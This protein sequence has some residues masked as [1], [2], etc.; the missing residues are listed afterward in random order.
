MSL[1]K[2]HVEI[3][4]DIMCP[5]C[6]I[7]KRKFDNALENFK[8]KEDV[9]VIWK[10]FELAPGLK[11]DTSKSIHQYL[12]ESKGMSANQVEQMVNQAVAMARDTGLN[13]DFNNVVVA[14]SRRGHQIIHLAAQYGLQHEMKER[15]L[16]AY[17]IEGE[18]VDDKTTLTRLG[19]E[20]GL[21]ELAI[22]DELESNNFDKHI[23]EDIAEASKLG[24]SGVPFFVFDRKYAISGAQP[25]AQFLTVLERSYS[26]WIHNQDDSN[27]EAIKGSSSSTQGDVD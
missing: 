22:E 20:V 12:Q 18:N 8:N 19:L 16:K 6:Y 4:S 7:G 26:E 15:L 3:W 14:S 10:S 24:V 23:D 21:P 9:E 1:N 13:Y 11:T 2:M 5:F 17:F 27:L 25:E